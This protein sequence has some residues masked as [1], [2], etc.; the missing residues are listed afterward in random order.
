MGDRPL[1]LTWFGCTT[2]RVEVGGRT[3]FFDT[4]MD[5]PPGV[6]EVGMSASEVTDA[7]L[8][9]ISHAHFDH[10]L[11]A[12]TIA[13]ATGATV[14]GSHETMRVLR[15]NGVP[16]EQLLR[17]SGG[18]PVDC[19]GGV[20]VRVYPSLHSCLFGSPSSP[21]THTECLGDLGISA[22]DRSASAAAIFE[23]LRQVLP[24]AG[25]W[26]AETAHRC[27]TH[28]GGQLSYLL[29]TPDGSIFVSASAGGWTGLLRD[30]RPD[31]AILALAGRP[32]VDGEPFQGSLA[33]FL[34][35]EVELLKPSTVVLCHHDA[36]LPPILPAIDTEHALATLAREAGHATHVDL[37]YGD[38]V[39]ILPRR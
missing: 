37:T 27:S 24:G 5:R 38:P 23:L 14:V 22:Q 25:P 19:G 7:D 8:V 16:D 2:F 36:L 30:L 34:L 29:E 4:Y 18:E 39:A 20:T 31:V 9:F 3:L 1:S 11:G 28:D 6:P 13:N 33:S 26:L 35:Q 15:D 32:N 21:D 17:V 12:D 10:M